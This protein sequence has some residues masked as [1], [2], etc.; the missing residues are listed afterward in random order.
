MRL[1]GRRACS[2]RSLESRRFRS[3]CIFSVPLWRG[4]VAIISSMAA[5]FSSVD[6]AL[7]K[8]LSASR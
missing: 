2:A 6:L 8:R 5:I 3:A 4:I 7:L 1:E